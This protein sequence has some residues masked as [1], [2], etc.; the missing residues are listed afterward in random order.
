MNLT[1]VEQIIVVLVIVVA[2]L[3]IMVGMCNG[4]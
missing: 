2:G 4:G 3:M 1:K